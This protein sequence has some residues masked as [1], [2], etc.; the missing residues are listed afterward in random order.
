MHQIISESLSPLLVEV[1]NRCPTCQK[2]LAHRVGVAHNW[3][4]Y[5]E[6]ARLHLQDPFCPGRLCR[7]GIKEHLAQCHGLEY[8]LAILQEPQ[9]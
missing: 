1:F 9:P 6:T 3:L 8:T 4:V 5:M 7:S 2:I